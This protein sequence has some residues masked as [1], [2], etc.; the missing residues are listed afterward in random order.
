MELLCRMN[1]FDL[2]IAPPNRKY[3]NAKHL[4]LD[5]YKGTDVRKFEVTVLTQMQFLFAGYMQYLIFLS[6]ALLYLVFIS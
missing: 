3:I 2:S 4:T 6:N 5:D 1:I